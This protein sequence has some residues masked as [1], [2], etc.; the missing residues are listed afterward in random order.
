MSKLPGP[1]F[2][3]GLAYVAR[4]KE[5]A[6]TDDLRTQPPYLEG[7]PAVVAIADLAGARTIINVPMLKAGRL[8]GTI[9]IFRQ[10]VRPF[11]QPPLSG[12]GGM[13]V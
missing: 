1:Y 10:E 9:S 4:T 7:D 2:R 13:L 5:I 12:P 11:D 3:A 6:H 8:V